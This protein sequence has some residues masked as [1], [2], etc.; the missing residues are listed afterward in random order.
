M[1]LPVVVEMLSDA[2]DR[3]DILET[4]QQRLANRLRES[5]WRNMS[6]N[7]TLLHVTELLLRDLMSQEAFNPVVL[8]LTLQHLAGDKDEEGYEPKPENEF[9]RY[10]CRQLVH[11]ILPI[12]RNY[13]R[14]QA[15]VAAGELFPSPRVSALP[16]AGSPAGAAMIA[17][18]NDVLLE[19]REYLLS[20]VAGFFHV[21]DVPP[22]RLH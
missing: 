6:L 19:K 2:M 1:D 20:N 12:V 16:E 9:V 4:E 21:Q 17:D 8:F 14:H 3:I 11:V 13:Q 22:S 10:A 18:L 7:L 15:P 5:D